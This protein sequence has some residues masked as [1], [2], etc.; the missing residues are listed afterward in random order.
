MIMQETMHMVIRGDCHVGSILSSLPL[1][2]GESKSA[3]RY[4]EQAGKLMADI[5][6]R[7]A[8]PQ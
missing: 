8:L 7:L 4:E 6:F 5:G 2:M 1:D 3:V